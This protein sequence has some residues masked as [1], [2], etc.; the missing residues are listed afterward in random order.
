MHRAHASTVGIPTYLPHGIGFLVKRE[1]EVLSDSMTNPKRPL[2]VIMGGAKV[3]DKLGVI[4]A[5]AAKADHIFIGPALCFTFLK[6]LSYNVG[7]SLICEEKVSMCKDL[8]DRYKDKIILPTDI[9]VGSSF[10]PMSTTRLCKIADICQNDIGMDVGVETMD[11]L[12]K[13]LIEAG[14]VIWN[15]PVGVYEID[16]FNIG[17]R[18]MLDYLSKISAKVILGGGDVVAAANKF[19]YKN[20]FYHVSTGG[21]ATLEFMEGKLLPGLEIMKNE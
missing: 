10:T 12:R 19:G 1:V 6:A 7:Q 20:K 14:M 17:T 11:N 4:E 2:V 18:K 16:K 21:G 3:E 9:V 13:I 5:L 15:G 8:Y